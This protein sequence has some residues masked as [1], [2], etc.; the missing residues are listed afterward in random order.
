MWHHSL[1]SRLTRILTLLKQTHL[2]RIDGI[3]GRLPA[4]RL[5]ADKLDEARE[6][7]RESAGV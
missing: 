2:N 1:A 3:P 4:Q 5:A 7:A 6:L